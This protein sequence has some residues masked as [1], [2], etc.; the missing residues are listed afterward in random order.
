MPDWNTFRLVAAAW[1]ASDDHCAAH[2]PKEVDAA[3]RDVLD[4][5]P[6]HAEQSLEADRPVRIHIDPRQRSRHMKPGGAV[7]PERQAGAATPREAGRSSCPESPSVSSVSLASRPL[8]GGR[9]CSGVEPVAAGRPVD[10]VEIRL[11]GVAHEAVLQVEVGSSRQLRPTQGS[12]RG[13]SWVGTSVS[14]NNDPVWSPIGDLFG[15][16]CPRHVSQVGQGG[17]RPPDPTGHENPDRDQLPDPLGD[18]DEPVRV[19]HLG[20]ERADD[21]ELHPADVRLD[22]THLDRR[23]RCFGDQET[24]SR[25]PIT[26]VFAARTRTSIDRP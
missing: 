22:D 1:G 6:V 15:P 26:P 4:V 10:A 24:R 16:G 8:Q 23:T 21:S 11:A 3:Q 9:R 2:R 5:C 17:R 12:R 25:S 19:E 13:R 14:V 20:F 18:V 7:E